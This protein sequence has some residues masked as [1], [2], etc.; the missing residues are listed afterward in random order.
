MARKYEEP[1]AK[2]TNDAYTGMLGLSLLALLVGCAVL[3][4]DYAAYSDK[5]PEKVNFSKFKARPDREQSEARD[6][7][8]K[9]AVAPDE[10]KEAP[11]DDAQEGK[12]G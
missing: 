1:K 8:K 4:M 11:K 3:Y 6:P 9:D 2:P 7:G 10:G 5:P 12:K